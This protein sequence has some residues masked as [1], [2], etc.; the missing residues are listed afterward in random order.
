VG[1]TGRLLTEAHANVWDGGRGRAISCGGRHKAKLREVRTFR[2]YRVHPREKLLCEKCKVS[3]LDQ[4]LSFG[5]NSFAKCGTAATVDEPPFADDRLSKP[6][7]TMRG[8]SGF[9]SRQLVLFGAG[10]IVFSFFLWTL[11]F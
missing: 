3:C 11:V 4:S 10:A 9:E 7:M 2:D 1:C 6:P 8:S 5:W